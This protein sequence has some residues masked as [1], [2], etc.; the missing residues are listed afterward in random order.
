MGVEFQQMNQPLIRIIINGFCMRLQVREEDRI[1]DFIQMF[2][3]V[4][5]S[6]DLN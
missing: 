2:D 6:Q 3:P 4:H 5:L 1:E